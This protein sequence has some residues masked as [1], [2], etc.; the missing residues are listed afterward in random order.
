MKLDIFIEKFLGTIL[1]KEAILKIKKI[2]QDD[3]I[4][5]NLNYNTTSVESQVFTENSN[6][7]PRVEIT[8]DAY[9][10]GEVIF[11]DYHLD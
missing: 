5:N 9:S 2:I 3:M 7:E 4:E 8:N 11:I 10:D 6:Y 1:T